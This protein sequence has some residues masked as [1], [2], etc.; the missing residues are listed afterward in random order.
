[1]DEVLRLAMKLPDEDR[2][3]LAEALFSSVEPAG[4][5]PFDAEW[6]AEAKRHAARIDAG[7]GRTST[8]AEVRERARTSLKEATAGPQHSSN[9]ASTA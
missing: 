9:W 4:Q 6:I 1:M 2:L 8:W 7:E 5:L 3:R